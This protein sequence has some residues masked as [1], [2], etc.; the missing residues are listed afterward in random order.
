VIHKAHGYWIHEAGSPSPEPPLEGAHRFDAV[1]VGG[2]F[3]GLWTAWHLIQSDPGL[4]VALVEAQRI[5]HGPSGRNGGFV[6]AM[7]VSFGSLVKRYGQG[8]ALDLAR[9]AER[10]VDQIGEFCEKQGVDAWYRKSGYLN[11]STAPAQDDSWDGNVEAM[12]AAGI[13]DWPRILDQAE[14]RE[15]CASPRFRGGVHYGVAA[16]V[17]PARLGFGIRAALL[18]HGVSLFEDSPVLKIED[19]RLGVEVSTDRG[20][21]TAERLVL[22]NGPALAGRG[23]PLRHNVTL[24]SSHMVITEPVPDVIEELGWDGGEAISDCRSLLTYFRT[25]PDGRIAFGWG[26]GRIAAGARRFG[27]AEVDPDVISGV[28]EG[29]HRY[30]PILAD[31]RIEY[32][33]GGPIDASATHLPHVVA[34]PSGR[35][36]AA[37]GYTGNGVG[38]SQMVGRSLAS[39]VLDRRDGYG[40]LP[41]IEPASALT[42]VP[43]E[44]FRWVG[45]TLI[46]EAI[47]RKEEAEMAERSPD[48][49][50]ATIA[51]IPELI[52][53][54]I[55]R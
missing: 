14:V 41:F 50:S 15:I 40:T 1:V 55:G 4:K 34:M 28:I 3:T 37:F 11:V 29:L 51:R 16:T 32:A 52:G 46:R 20:H 6:D 17:Q 27:K 18:E 49:V 39:L 36:F 48:P 43:P 26:G 35:S 53:F 38:P 24:A 12:R 10:S 2:G 54:H 47:G 33:W 23:S 13:E 19:G 21:I 42:K 22:A 9:S 31:R 25:T 44:P 45:G 8:P 7:W 5:A 30:F